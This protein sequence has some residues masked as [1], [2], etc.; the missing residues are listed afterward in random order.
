MKNR[1]K[2]RMKQYISRH[3]LDIGIIMAAIVVAVGVNIVGIP[4]SMQASATKNL[5]VHQISAKQ[6]FVGELND[7]G[8]MSMVY[9][10][11]CDEKAYPAST[12]KIMTALIVL[13]TM[14]KLSS[15]I[16]QDITTPDCAVGAEGSS[17]YLKK[18]EEISIEDLLYGMMLRSGNDAALALAQIIGGNVENFVDRMNDRAAEL[19]C[20]NTNFANPSGLFD[21]N[22]Y[23]T[24][25]E[26]AI[27]TAEAMKNKDFRKIVSA[28]QYNAHREAN[29]YS[30]FYN[31]NKTVH[32][33]EGGNGVKI[34][35]TKKSGRT[36]V[37][38]AE[39]EEKTVICV[40]MNAPDWF[41]DA[42]SLMDAYFENQER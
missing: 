13:E 5:V 4:E 20:V 25:R 8:K 21:E 28:K 23:T 38:S 3:R 24:A 34:G 37:A 31:K 7:N 29:N 19:G 11:N 14:E 12:T 1:I 30:Y 2:Q 39:R 32:Q 36:L 26:M 18:G 27:I 10:K 6:A 35:Y 41:N 17:I 9:E 42:Y 33:Y 16:E 15:P 40:V 22:H